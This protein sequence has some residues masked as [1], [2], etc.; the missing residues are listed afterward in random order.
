MSKKEKSQSIPIRVYPEYFEFMDKGVGDDV[1]VDFARTLKA[2]ADGNFDHEPKTILIQCIIPSISREIEAGRK[3]YIEKVD[4]NRNNGS[5]GGNKTRDKWKNKG[6]ESEENATPDATPNATPDATPINLF[7]DS[8]IKLSPPKGGAGGGVFSFRDYYKR[9]KAALESL[10]KDIKDEITLKQTVW[11]CAEFG[12][13]YSNEAA[14]IIAS[15]KHEGG[16]ERE[17][18]NKLQTLYPKYKP[19]SPNDAIVLAIA[20]KDIPD[21]RV[22]III[23]E[24]EAHQTETDIYKTMLGKINHAKSHEISDFEKFVKNRN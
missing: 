2:Y 8:S 18:T 1:I 4:K 6:K 21:S 16:N 14:R 13:E 20:L 9:V 15:W 23:N 12:Q 10:E 24:V 7:I 11:R 22:Q 17:L 3:A 19:L 5:K